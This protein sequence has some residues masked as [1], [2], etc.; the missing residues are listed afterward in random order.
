M[1]KIIAAMGVVAILAAM[2]FSIGLVSAKSGGQELNVDVR[3]TFFT[4]TTG[5]LP[6]GGMVHVK[7]DI[8]AEGDVGGTVIGQVNIMVMATEPVGVNQAMGLYVY[9]I[10]GKGEIYVSTGPSNSRDPDGTTGAI[11]GGTGQFRGISGESNFKTEPLVGS[12][13]NFKFNS[14]TD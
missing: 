2:I 4:E 13:V 6:E 3:T 11:T 9:K 10:F 7:Q 1:N 14:R 12:S 8:F 5:D